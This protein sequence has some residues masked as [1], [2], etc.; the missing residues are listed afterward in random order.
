MNSHIEKAMALRNEVPMVN[1]CA[2]TLLRV[3]ADELGLN[4]ETAANLACNFGGGMK[5]GG[6]CGVITGAL[7]VLGAKGITDAGKVNS[8]R[9]EIALSHEGLTDCA[10]LLKANAAKGGEK[11]AHCDS[12]IKQAIEIIDKLQ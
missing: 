10:E 11:K 2:Q 3:Y 1:N 7:M 5:C 12:M 8:V 4:E 6:T 9:K